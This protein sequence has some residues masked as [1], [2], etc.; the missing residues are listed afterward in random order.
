MHAFLVATAVAVLPLALTGCTGD[1]YAGSGPAAE[2]AVPPA[3][4]CP[5][6]TQGWAV[7]LDKQ[8]GPENTHALVV[9]GEALVP[10][11]TAPVLSPGITDRMMPPSQ[12]FNLSLA[13][14][15]GAEGGWQP[16]R[17][18]IT[19]A[20]PHYRSI[21]IGCGGEPLATVTDIKIVE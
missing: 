21:I 15:P 8:P 19:P 20:L 10:A 3:Q 1:A 13:S 12:R 6:E 16:V 18:M 2:P 14:Q 11:G 7:W 5:E 9:T 4:A 17:A